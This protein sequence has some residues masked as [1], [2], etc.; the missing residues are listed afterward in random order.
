MTKLVHVIHDLLE[1]H[2]S[3]SNN[4]IE[5]G[6]E[7][8]DCR[9]FGF[10]QGELVTVT[11]RFKMPF[12]LLLPFFV[13]KI[14]VGQQV[15]TSVFLL[16][17]TERCFINRL[18][19]TSC[20]LTLEMLSSDDVCKKVANEVVGSAPILIHETPRLN[21]DDLE[22]KL[23]GD[24]SEVVFISGADR[25]IRNVRAYDEDS[26]VELSKALKDLALKHHCVI[27]FDAAMPIRNS[28]G[29]DLV[30]P[31][32]I[33]LPFSGSVAAFS[34]IVLHIEPPENLLEGLHE[35]TMIENIHGYFAMGPVDFKF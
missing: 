12:E 16:D 20:N 15:R 13:N 11:S 1:K 17:S 9:G 7:D 28:I 29:E 24:S 4:F 8:I 30:S 33:D 2:D 25:F 31:R 35:V 6:I 22:Q 10:R 3:F 19:K 34:D 26:L 23:M 27:V 32:A 18:L 5:T 14:G 21:L